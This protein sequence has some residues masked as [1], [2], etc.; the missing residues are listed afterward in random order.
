MYE[1]A[2]KNVFGYFEQQLASLS[3]AGIRKSFSS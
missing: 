1:Q 3:K 2:Y